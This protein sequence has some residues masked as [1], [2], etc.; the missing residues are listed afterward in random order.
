MI[1][2]AVED[3]TTFIDEL[4]GLLPVHY[5]ELCVTK[6]FPL[7]PDYVAYGRLCAADMLKCIVARSDGELVGYALFI[8]QPHLHYV[9]C[10]TAF[11]DVYFLRKD[12]RLGRTGIR[13]F[14]F[15]EQAL[16]DAGVN[17]IIMHTKIHLD[18]SKLF[19]YLGYKMTDKLYTKLLSTE[20]S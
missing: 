5:D 4:K 1:E 10:K 6:D 2:Y 14:Q 20:P 11:E 7:M 15:A 19:E 8:V 12:H 18:N 3:P 13:L 9:T 16:K 17:R